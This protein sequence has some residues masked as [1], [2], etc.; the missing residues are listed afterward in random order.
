M[1]SKA[2]SK[3]RA[4][5]RVK[6]E[7]SVLSMCVHGMSGKQLT[8]RIQYELNK[9]PG[10]VRQYYDGHVKYNRNMDA[11]SK[12]EFVEHLLDDKNFE[13]DYWR[14]VKETTHSS[15]DRTEAEW[16][17][18]REMQLHEDPQVLDLMIQ[19]KKIL[20]RPHP[21]LDHNDPRTAELDWKQRHQFKRKVD[22]E[23]ED[24]TCTKSM[25]Q[26][27]DKAPPPTAS[28]EQQVEDA[29]PKHKKLIAEIRKART[30]FFNAESDLDSKLADMSNNEYVRK[31]H[32]DASTMQ[33]DLKEMSKELSQ[34]I[35]KLEKT[36]DII[37]PVEVQEAQERACAFQRMIKEVKSRIAD[38]KQFCDKHSKQGAASHI[39]P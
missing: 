12:K 4:K 3:A 33:A 8:N 21:D 27:N 30:A 2:A 28:T 16:V 5:A 36:D 25:R 11:A 35:T 37:S 32:E 34:D 6:H 13:G 23:I 18:F 9:K 38:M 10:W 29:A 14:A 26:G 17:S 20:T 7:Q 15:T 31:A 39:A 22:K 24:V 19:Q 1:A